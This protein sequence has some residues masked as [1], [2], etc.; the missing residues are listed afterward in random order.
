MLV[1]Q[2]SRI[3][4]VTAG[5]GGWEERYL[6]AGKRRKGIYVLKLFVIYMDNKTHSYSS[7]LGRCFHKD[8]VTTV[9]VLDYMFKNGKRKK[10]RKKKSRKRLD[11][12]EPY[13][14]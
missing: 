11:L 1:L 12:S 10:E 4:D 8:T 14:N 2:R 6:T 9:Q 5:E 13:P 3:P 7:W